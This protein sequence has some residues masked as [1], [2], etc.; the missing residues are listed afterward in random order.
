MDEMTPQEQHRLA[1]LA[2]GKDVR[3]YKGRMH[4]RCGHL[5]SYAGPIWSP[6]IDDGDSARLRTEL[7]IEVSFYKNRLN[8]RRPAVEV[9]TDG[10]VI[11]WENYSDHAGDKHAALRAATMRVAVEIGK[12]A[13]RK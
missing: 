4:Y 11:A 3:W 7:G 12:R 2:A 6:M 10:A 9:V 5:Q 8:A 13:E 1:A